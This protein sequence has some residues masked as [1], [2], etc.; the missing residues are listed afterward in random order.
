M[1]AMTRVAAALRV[2]EP[3][4]VHS[5]HHTG[6]AHGGPGRRRWPLSLLTIACA[7]AINSAYGQ[8]SAADEAASPFAL[9]TT[10]VT[11]TRTANSSFEL[12]ASVSTVERQQLDE[13]QANTLSTALR[14]LPNVNYG[15]G[16]RAAA[17]S[18]AIRGLQGPRIILTVDGARRNN[19]GGVNTPLLIDPDLIRQ[20]DVVRGPMSAAYGSG[21]LGGVMAIE[22]LNADD[23][24]DPGQSSRGRHQAGAPSANPRPAP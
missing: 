4:A 10:T 15:G 3:F 11:A 23:M 19:D 24:L 22:T 7:L 8:A 12:P 6:A 18:P 21:G 20:I 17:Q 2:A 14:T 5:F 13:V 16:P 9:D 1:S